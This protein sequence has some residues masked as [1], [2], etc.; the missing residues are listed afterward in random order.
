M[1]TKWKRQYFSKV[2]CVFILLIISLENQWVMCKVVN[3]YVLL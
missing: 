2:K 3:T 1:D